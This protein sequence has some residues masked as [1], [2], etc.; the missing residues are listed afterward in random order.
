[1][2]VCMYM[3]RPCLMPAMR[4]AGRTLCRGPGPASPGGGRRRLARRRAS[5]PHMARPAATS[6]GAASAAGAAVAALSA[7]HHIHDTPPPPPWSTAADVATAA[8]ASPPAP[9]TCGQCRLPQFRGALFAQICHQPR[10]LAVV[11]VPAEDTRMTSR[12][13][14][15]HSQ[16]LPTMAGRRCDG[17][18]E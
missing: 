10:Y 15:E 8:A 11:V 4:Y 18:E 17:N 13:A 1:M 14:E 6:A 5:A 9:L 16:P 7:S 12:I 3:P 2:S